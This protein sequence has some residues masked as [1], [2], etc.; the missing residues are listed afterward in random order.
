MDILVDEAK[1]CMDCAGW[2]H[3]CN[4]SCCRQF[5]VVHPAS[6]SRF[7]PLIFLPMPRTAD[8]Q[9][10]YRL[11]GCRIAHGQLVIRTRN[12]H[13]V[14]KENRLVFHRKCDW[15]GEDNR[16]IHYSERP[17]VCKDFDELGRGKPQG[18]YVTEG[19]LA[20]YKGVIQDGA[21]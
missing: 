6:T 21:K 14:R 18:A 4:A 20:N 17:S 2:L 9:L 8:R 16:C 15:L 7:P 19:C 1:K 13:V 5:S 11:H 12:Y 3:V 10:Y